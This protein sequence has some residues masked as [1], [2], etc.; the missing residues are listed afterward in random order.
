MIFI[1]GRSDDTNP[2]AI[3]TPSIIR[4]CLNPNSAKLMVMFITSKIYLFT[5]MLATYPTMLAN[6]PFISAIIML[7]MRN[8][9]NMFLLLAPSAL[10]MPIVCLFEEILLVI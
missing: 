8:I 7:S 5:N 2:V 9:I 4:T 10:S 1:I 3:L 6:I